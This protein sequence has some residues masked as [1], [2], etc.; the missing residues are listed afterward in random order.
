MT[1]SKREEPTSMRI[2]ILVS[3][4]IKS[5]KERMAEKL[6]KLVERKAIHHLH[7]LLVLIRAIHLS[8]IPL[9]HQIKV[10]KK[11]IEREMRKKKVKKSK[12]NLVVVVV[13]TL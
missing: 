3:S 4:L 2:G 8:L 9:I 12:I 11:F 13:A 5:Y 1:T 6:L 7:H 10:E